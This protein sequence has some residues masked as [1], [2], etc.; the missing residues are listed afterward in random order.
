MWRFPEQVNSVTGKDV[1]VKSARVSPDP[2]SDPGW[3]APGPLGCRLLGTVNGRR[4]V[5]VNQAGTYA[6]KRSPAA[7]KT[8]TALILKA[9]PEGKL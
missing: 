1:T 4:E 9:L 3:L 7:E 2:E 8:S 6:S 5:E